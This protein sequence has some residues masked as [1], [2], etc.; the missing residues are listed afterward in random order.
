MA[1]F[2]NHPMCDKCWIDQH[3]VEEDDNLFSLTM[4]VKV[5]LFTLEFCCWCGDPTLSGIYVHATRD[6][7]GMRCHVD[8][9]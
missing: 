1:T 8:G 7:A 3:T 9:H 2:S 5:E 4:P 6:A